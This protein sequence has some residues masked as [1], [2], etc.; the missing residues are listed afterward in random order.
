[1]P[2]LPASWLQTVRSHFKEVAKSATRE[3]I[4][5]N[6]KCWVP[7]AIHQAQQ[8]QHAVFVS[9]DNAT[10]HQFTQ[11]LDDL[12]LHPTQYLELPPL[13]PDLHQ[14]VEHSL[15][16]VK[17][18]LVVTLS[19]AGW[20]NVDADAVRVALNGIIPAVCAPTIMQADMHNV[21]S[22]Y[23]VVSTPVGQGSWDGQKWVQG[24]G[25][26]YGPKGVR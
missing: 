24:T 11:P 20:D 8:G 14:L 1:M 13:S 22:C 7:K 17:Q 10:I 16:R 3:E 26:G 2:A 6:C 25:G 18:Q 21:I 9:W 15:G 4:W 19:K 5:D 12:G 23:H